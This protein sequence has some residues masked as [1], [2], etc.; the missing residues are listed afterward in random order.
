MDRFC[1]RCNALV[2]NNTALC[3]SCI[4]DLKRDQNTK[5][6]QLKIKEEKEK[7]KWKTE[8]DKPENN[9]FLQRFKIANPYSGAAIYYAIMLLIIF[10]G[11]IIFLRPITALL[12]EFLSDGIVGSVITALTIIWIG[13]IFSAS[14]RFLYFLYKLIFKNT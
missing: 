7:N 8:W 10:F 13:S 3:P 2:F 4:E 12:L 5:E 11:G 6:K 14:R 1:K 9:D